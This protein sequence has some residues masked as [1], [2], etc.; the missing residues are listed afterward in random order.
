MTR[1]TNDRTDRPS[2]QASANELLNE[3]F[4]TLLR[5]AAEKREGRAL[6]QSSEDAVAA[7]QESADLLALARSQASGQRAAEF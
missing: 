3:E 4:H 7:K 1:A 2:R 6:L 5:E